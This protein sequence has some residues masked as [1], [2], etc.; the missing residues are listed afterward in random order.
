VVKGTVDEHILK[1]S[2]TKIDLMNQVLEENNQQN[3]IR[4]FIE[5]ALAKSAVKD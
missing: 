2:N 1:Q 3:E 4:T 5:Q